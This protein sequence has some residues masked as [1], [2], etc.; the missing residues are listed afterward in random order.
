MSLGEILMQAAA[1]RNYFITSTV[2]KTSALE[3]PDWSCQSAT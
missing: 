1:H 3:Q 2:A